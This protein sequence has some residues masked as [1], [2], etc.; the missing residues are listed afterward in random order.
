MLILQPLKKSRDIILTPKNKIQPLSYFHAIHSAQP[1]RASRAARLLVILPL[2]TRLIERTAPSTFIT[3]GQWPP[4]RLY[5]FRAAGQLVKIKGKR[6]QESRRDGCARCRANRRR[7]VD[8]FLQ[9]I[10]TNVG[11]P[12]EL[13]LSGHQSRRCARCHLQPRIRTGCLKGLTRANRRSM[14]ALGTGS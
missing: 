14:C 7:G 5:V 13:R 9:G 2:Y 6:W 4:K 1:S 3:L 8:L 11:N 10:Q 12:G